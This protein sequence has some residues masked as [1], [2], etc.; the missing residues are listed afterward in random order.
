MAATE[1]AAA[2]AKKIATAILTSIS[3]KGKNGNDSD[4]ST[5]KVVTVIIAA[6]LIVAF[7][8]SAA[9][10]TLFGIDNEANAGTLG[11][12]SSDGLYPL[13]DASSEITDESLRFYV[14][15]AKRLKDYA[16]QKWPGDG[17]SYNTPNWRWLYALD[18]AYSDND[19]DKVKE[20]A[21]AYR[22][23]HERALKATR[24]IRT[25]YA[26]QTSKEK[27]ED[28]ETQG[29]S[30]DDQQ[31][32][33]VKTVEV[34]T[35]YWYVTFRTYKEIFRSGSVSGA[36]GSLSD[37]MK[38]F[39]QN[40]CAEYG[41]GW[42]DNGNALGYY[43][44]DRRY[45]LP[46]FLEFCIDRYPGLFDQFSPWAGVDHINQ[47]DPALEAAWISAF[48]LHPAE[49]SSAQ[50][51]FGY[52]HYYLTAEE[53]A[54][55]AGVELSNRRDCIKGLFWGVT[56]LFGAGGAESI[57][58]GSGVNDTMDDAAIANAL[59]NYIIKTAPGNYAY[60]QAYARRYEAELETVLYYL[61]T[62]P[63]Q[64]D[65]STTG[66]DTADHGFTNSERS[67]FVENYYRALACVEYDENTGKATYDPA[68]FSKWMVEGPGSSTANRDWVYYNQGDP[69]WQSVGGVI[70]SGDTIAQSG[71]AIT[72]IAMIWATYSGDA[73]IDPISVLAIGRAKGVFTSDNLVMPQNLPAASAEYGLDG[74]FV[75]APTE[76]DWTEVEDATSKGG[77]AL[78]NFSSDG[79][80]YSF[81][82]SGHFV[83]VVGVSEDHQTVY[84]ADPGSRAAT[85]NQVEDSGEAKIEINYEA[86]KRMCNPGLGTNSKNMVILWPAGE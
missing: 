72:S 57:I 35:T 47:G 26:V 65:G 40:E 54:R 23:M 55:E 75:S 36:Q 86:F 32:M 22:K 68:R 80:G 10:V 34:H 25:D 61:G 1:A 66:P 76:S 9:P 5:P 77:C 45:S 31:K 63:Q 11:L 53:T 38:Y 30:Y 13:T 16:V 21:D 48:S 29:W 7:V 69:Q 17:S 62:A 6:L 3:G 46:A 60:G 2:A 4:S 8:I 74:R 42:G 14:L 24:R 67:I 70:G 51:E 84:L 50:D 28:A 37:E 20:N 43:Q 82:T 39:A 41:V 27:P 44:Y 33:W 56:N 79:T 18:T 83:V 85:W 49:F 58:R 81:A 78:V 52:E 64:S 59:C 12:A 15:E 19:F 71:C 73:T